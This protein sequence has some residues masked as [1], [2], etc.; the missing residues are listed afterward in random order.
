MT[1]KITRDLFSFLVKLAAFSE[2]PLNTQTPH[3]HRED[4]SLHAEAQGM[5]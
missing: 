4:I 3:L 2:S 1:L 5:L